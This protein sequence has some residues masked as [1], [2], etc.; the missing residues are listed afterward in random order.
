MSKSNKKEKKSKNLVE[1]VTP[2]GESSQTGGPNVDPEEEAPEEEEEAPEE[3]PAAKP[4]ILNLPKIN[5]KTFLIVHGKKADQMAMF[6][7]HAKKVGLG[8]ITIPEWRSE[9]EKYMNTPVN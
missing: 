8:P 2:V 6:A 3:V 9:F 7:H 1:G 5:L 4:S